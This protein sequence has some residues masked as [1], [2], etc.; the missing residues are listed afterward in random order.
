M[1]PS[2]KAKDVFLKTML[3]TCGKLVH[4]TPIHKEREEGNMSNGIKLCN[5]CQ[6]IIL[7][8]NIVLYKV[9]ALFMFHR[10]L[11]STSLQHVNPFLHNHVYYPIER[12]HLK[13]P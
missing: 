10:T 8:M 11:F 1:I 9:D 3:I 7:I 6:V 12:S 5:V 4:P 13:A 2:K